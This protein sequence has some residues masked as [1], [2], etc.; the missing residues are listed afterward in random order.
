MYMD[1]SL[2]VLKASKWTYTNALVAKTLKALD[3]WATVFRV[4]IDKDKMELLCIQLQGKDK[5]LDPSTVTHLFSITPTI[6]CVMTGLMGVSF[7]F[8]SETQHVLFF[9]IWKNKIK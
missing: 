9:P 8:P 7:I 1:I 4:H 3:L 5:L 2:F 6:G